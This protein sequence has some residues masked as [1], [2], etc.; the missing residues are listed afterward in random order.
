[1]ETKGP[2]SLPIDVF[3]FLVAITCSLV[4]PLTLPGQRSTRGR[5]E[6]DT[7]STN[8]TLPIK[9]KCNL[10]ASVAQAA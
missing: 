5:A 9:P 2:L 8:E 4:N 10:Y 1:M 7:A 3:L 6:T